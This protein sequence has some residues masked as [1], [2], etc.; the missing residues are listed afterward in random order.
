MGRMARFSVLMG[1][2]DRG[3]KT[4]SLLLKLL[5]DLPHD[6]RAHC[7][8]IEGFMT[9]WDK[10]ELGHLGKEKAGDIIEA[11]LGLGWIRMNKARAQNAGIPGSGVYDLAGD[12]CLCNYVD[13]TVLWG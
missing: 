13:N 4:C 10:Y 6:D 5:L 3:N 7:P 2:K 1:A 8:Y 12:V 9:S 11:V